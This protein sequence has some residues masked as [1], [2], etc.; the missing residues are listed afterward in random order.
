MAKITLN[1]QEMLRLLRAGEDPAPY[2]VVFDDT[3][4]EALDAIL[5]GKHGFLVPEELIWYD[6]EAINYEDDPGLTDEDL[7]SGKLIRVLNLM[8]PVEK[9]ISDWVKAE[10]ID[11]NRLVAGL[12][13]SIYQNVKSG[14]PTGG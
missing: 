9:E 11:L 12:L 13:R 1:Q 10:K 14:H 2:T 6:D 7:E 8:V 5:L 3:K 4:V